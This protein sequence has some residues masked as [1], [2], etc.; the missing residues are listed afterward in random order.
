M[1]KGLLAYVY[2]NRPVSTCNLIKGN[3]VLV[4]GDGI[5]EVS[6]ANGNEVVVL[7]QGAFRGLAKI[8]PLIEPD[9]MC[10]GM[11][12]NAYI[13]CSDS[14]FNDA[15][16]KII[17]AKHFHGAVPLHDWSETWENYNRNLD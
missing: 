6:E 5:P 9:Y 7:S 17:G 13:A 1:I 3:Q 14:R 12:G 11:F 8:T 10:N 2:R 16:A 15:V 4:I